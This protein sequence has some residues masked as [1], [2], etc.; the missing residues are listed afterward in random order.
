[1]GSFN[2]DW[3]DYGGDFLGDPDYVANNPWH[4]YPL[5]HDHGDHLFPFAGT[6][7]VSRANYPLMI[8]AEGSGKGTVFVIP[9][10]DERQTVTLQA[11]PDSGSYFAGWT[12][13]VSGNDDSVVLTLGDGRAVTARFESMNQIYLP[14]IIH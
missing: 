1:V 9:T 2:L 12:G 4:L 3:W 7:L 13:D 6:A 5:L 14:L 8:D 11:I 10:D